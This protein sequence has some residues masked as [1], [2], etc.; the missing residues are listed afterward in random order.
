MQRCLQSLDDQQVA[1]CVADA[2]LI[3]IEGIKVECIPL[4]TCNSS[5]SWKL[6]NESEP[7]QSTEV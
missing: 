4:A 3:I 7:T 2:Q 6:F 5:V 1:C